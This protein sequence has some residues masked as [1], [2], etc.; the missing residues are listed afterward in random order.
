MAAA[1]AVAEVEVVVVADGIVVAV[2]VAERDIVAVVEELELTWV[3]VAVVDRMN[4]LTLCSRYQS[5]V[6]SAQIDGT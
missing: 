1:A 2:V 4:S 3:A 6:H 5:T